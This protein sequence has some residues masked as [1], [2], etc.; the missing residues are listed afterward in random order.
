MI[1]K[2]V[3]I[4]VTIK[5]RSVVLKTEPPIKSRALSY[6]IPKQ[7]NTIHQVVPML[8]GAL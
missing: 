2:A 4:I 3:A 1:E 8:K 7:E 5:D 6:L